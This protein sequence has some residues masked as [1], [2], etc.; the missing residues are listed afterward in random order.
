MTGTTGRSHGLRNIAA[1]ATPRVLM[2]ESGAKS[3]PVWRARVLTLFPEMF[4]GPLGISLTGKALEKRIWTLETL[5]IRAFAHDKHRSVDDTPAGGGPGMVLRPE[6]VARAIDASL[7]GAP[8]DRTRWPVIAL[9]AR[10][11][12][13]TQE[14][15]ARLSKAEGVSLLCGRFEGIDQRVIEA[16]GVEEIGIGD[17]VYTGGEIPAMALLDAVVR[18]LPGVLGKIESTEDESFSAGLLEHP[19]YTKPPVWEGRAIPEVLLSGHHAKVAAWRRTQ[20]ETV[21]K[22]RRPDLWRAFRN[23]AE[24]Y[25][26]EEPEQSDAKHES[27]MRPEEG[28]TT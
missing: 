12:P 13:L 21:T 28:S 15:V 25:P 23:L 9:S 26:T 20:A 7:K 5:D 3:D 6:I 27:Q 19:Q 10:G 16:R 8:E 22:E 11:R 24:P 17:A 18:L 2:D 1:T 14:R 4:P